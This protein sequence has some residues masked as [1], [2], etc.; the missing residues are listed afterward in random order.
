MPVREF[1]CLIV[2]Q[3]LAGTSLAWR[4]AWTGMR[5]LLIDR[6]SAVTS[7]KV[8]AGLVTPITGQ[9][10]VKT[11]RFDEMWDLAVS[12]YR[13][14]ELVTGESLFQV[15]PLIRLIKDER[16]R[17][18]AEK[19]L[20]TEEYRSSLMELDRALD[21]TAFRSEQG[22]LQMPLAGQLDVPRYLSA[23]R[24]HFEREGGYLTT[25]LDLEHDI[26]IRD[27]QVHLAQYGLKAPRLIFCQGIDATSN[28]WFRNVRFKPAKG[29][30]LTLRIPGLTEQRAVHRGV[31]LAPFGA[32]LF[33]VGATYEWNQ[34]DNVPTPG[35]RD[36]LLRD[37]REFLL[38]PFEVIDH[39]AAVRPIHINQF[40][41]IGT[42]PEHHSLGY[43]NGLGSKG[44]LYAPFY[45]NQFLNT[46]RDGSRLDREV[47]LRLKREFQ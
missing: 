16:D 20:S 32:N 1:D 46:L 13:R 37:L 42:H 18:E 2:G 21:P 35:R 12:H 8:A 15:R 39:Q 11:S 34:L 7:S 14:V 47:D 36:E 9:R 29:E 19:R 38:L 4:M 33:K 28:P 5:V 24:R 27:D 6:D 43:F 17:I 31:W 30:I 22:G 26:E 40:P 41:V 10:W 44:T 25:N 3:G 45:A 23:S